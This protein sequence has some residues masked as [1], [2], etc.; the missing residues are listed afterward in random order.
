[1]SFQVDLTGA[2]DAQAIE[3]FDSNFSNDGITTYQS[4]NGAGMVASQ[5]AG[6]F[7]NTR[8]TGDTPTANQTVEGVFR[9]AS[10]AHNSPFFTVRHLPDGQGYG[11]GWDEITQSLL[12]VR[13]NNSGQYPGTTTIGFDDTFVPQ[14]GVDYAISGEVANLGGGDVGLILRIAGE[15]R[16]TGTDLAANSPLTAAGNQGMRGGHGVAGTIALSITGYNG[17]FA[18]PNTDPQ[19]DSAEPDATATVGDV[20]SND[21]GANFSDVDLDN[22]TFSV[23][24]APPELNVNTDTG[25]LS[26]TLTT[27]GIFTITVTADDGQGG[28]PAQDV[29]VLQ[30]DATVGESFVDVVN[31][32]TVSIYSV[33]Q[34][35]YTGAAPT[36][37]GQ[38]QFELQTSGARTLNLNPDGSYNTTPFLAVNETATVRYIDAAGVVQD[39]W[40][41]TFVPRFSFN[42]NPTALVRAG[43]L[44]VDVNTAS[45]TGLSAVDFSATLDGEAITVSNASDLGGNQYRLTLQIDQTF[46]RQHGSYQLMVTEDSVDAVANDVALSPPV[47]YESVILA[48][49]LDASPAWVS[50][51]DYGVAYGN[52]NAVKVGDVI[53]NGGESYYC[54]EAG[55]LNATPPTHL[56]GLTNSDSGVSLRHLDNLGAGNIA[57]VYSSGAIFGRTTPI[58]NSTT[59]PAG[60]LDGWTLR[61]LSGSALDNFTGHA[62][63]LADELSHEDVSTPDAINNTVDPDGTWRLASAPENDQTMGAFVIHSDGTVGATATITYDLTDVTPDAFT[64]ADINDAAL[65]TLIESAPI[66]IAGLEAPAPISVSDG[67]YS[68]DG[69]AFTTAPGT[70]SNGQQ[71]RAR[72]QSAP[73][74]TTARS[75]IVVI[76]S[77]FDVFTVTTLADP[78]AR[79]ISFAAL[80]PMVYSAA[81]PNVVLRGLPRANEVNLRII[82]LNGNTIVS[83]TATNTTDGIGIIPETVNTPSIALGTD[84]TCI[85]ILEDG[86]GSPPFI[87]T[88]EDLAL[89]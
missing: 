20:Y 81:H 69:G 41:V 2:P 4:D 26:G 8:Y 55:L 30:V 56:T 36:T 21:L 66:T 67:E 12:I 73:G 40:L 32:D 27:A 3:V 78:V 72:V 85:P 83:D 63:S 42:I 53:T 84:L 88:V 37:G 86:E 54:N 14:L 70:V 60:G 24:G 34:M 76:S 43:S 5:V 7:C 17:A 52:G 29:F 22:L 50:G 35:G 1:M 75:A 51:N 89:L 38:L 80:G 58:I 15:I 6:N 45:A 31:P 79:G 11:V 13:Y 25:V 57:E 59:T 48:G 82:L 33:F 68:I 74:F 77:L 28:T 44:Q 47:G 71:V 9:L 87:V 16:C 49:T 23:S 62:P 61:K 18:P 39:E 19:L 64:F 10:L 46:A 65:D